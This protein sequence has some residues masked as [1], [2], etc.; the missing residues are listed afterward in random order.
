MSTE[1]A[2]QKDKTSKRAVSAG[3]IGNVLEWFDYSIYGYF[4]VAISANFFPGDDPIVSLM[5]AFMVFGMGFVARPLGAF[6]FGHL[7]DKVGRRNTLSITVILMGICTFIMG[8][9]PTYNQ[10]G[11]A[12]PLI[13]ILVRLGQGVSSGGEWGSAV[14]FLGEYSRNDNRGLI[15]SFSQVGSA[16]GLLMGALTGMLFSNIMSQETLVTYG[17]RIAFMFGIVIAIF[18]YLLRKNVD[19]TP[20]FQKAEVVESPIK[21]A[22]QNHKG[23]MVKQFFLSSGSFV[24]YW[25][26]L[27]YMVTYINVFLK[28]PISTGFSL[29]AASLVAYAVFLPVFGMASDKFGRKPVMLF[30]GGG[31]VLLTY[32]LFS[33]LAKTTSY[34]PMLL[35]VITLAMFFAAYAGPQTVLMNEL[36]PAK[37]RVTCFSVPY[38]IGSAIFA[39]TCTS[40]ATW[41]VDKTGNVMAM[42]MYIIAVMAVTLVTLIFFIPETKDLDYER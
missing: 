9:L 19:E 20:V 28:L 15:V 12:A 34:A 41:L 6:I 33:V 40:V 42:P 30:G 3:F 37:V 22:F 35:V 25:L 32:P 5:L 2:V 26:I 7:G 10:I 27:S 17:W 1:A 36:Y 23:T 21:E 29:T 24:A 8:I 16:L 18:G 38:Q 13:L 31:L 39:G 4:A 14:S 11:A